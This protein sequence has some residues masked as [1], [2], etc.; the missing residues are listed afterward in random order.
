MLGICQ[1]PGHARRHLKDRSRPAPTITPTPTGT[2]AR[3]GAV[4]LY[5]LEDT[6]I[7]FSI[8]CNNFCS[9]AEVEL[10]EISARCW[11]SI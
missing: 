9:A 2:L 8:I 7:A 3:A 4:R 10:A 6:R 1:Q 11:R 5:R